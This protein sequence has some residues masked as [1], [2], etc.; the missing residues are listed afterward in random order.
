[1]LLIG[2][3]SIILLGTE[4]R[5][6]SSDGSTKIGVLVNGDAYNID[7]T[8]ALDSYEVI[9]PSVKNF[10]VKQYDWNMQERLYRYKP[11]YCIVSG[12]LPDILLQVP[13]PTIINA[14]QHLINRLKEHDIKPIII[15]ILPVSG[16]PVINMK[17]QSLN[18][19]IEDVAIQNEIPCFSA[20]SSMLINGELD[21][22]LTIDSMILNPR[23]QELFVTNIRNQINN[24]FLLQSGY[25]APKT[26]MENLV[27]EGIKDI[28]RKS[29]K[30]VEIVMLG[31]SITAGADWNKLLKR[32]DVRNAGQGGYTSGQ[33]L[34]Y[35]DLCVLAPKPKVCFM[36]AGI[37]DLF[38]D[39]PPSLIYQNQI[40]I[41]EMLSSHRI[42][43]IVQLTLHVR[44]DK[45]MNKRIDKMN[46][47]LTRYCK[48]NSI[49]YIDL[50]QQLSDENGLKDEYTTDGVHLTAEA[51][52]IWALVL[53]DLLKNN[54]N[55]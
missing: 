30:T 31:N 48:E 49:F 42:K 16:Y 12:G 9:N 45:E 54:I 32:Q 19:L 24:Y 6:Q 47:V 53:N 37:N 3:V 43:P 36:M 1:M 52:A 2:F 39:L 46:E 20:D 5:A 50:N 8:K 4:T 25:T 41:I 44:G 7:W 21:K 17:I 33:M 14:Y 26:T 29:P 28:L 11:D 34:W 10:L 27:S 35:I 23:G 55:N 15:K 22:T 51:Y 13:F 40:K 38:N 18:R